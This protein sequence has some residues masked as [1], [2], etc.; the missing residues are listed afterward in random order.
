MATSLTRVKGEVKSNTIFDLIFDACQK[1]SKS[2][3]SSRVE[4]S[5]DNLY[6]RKSLKAKKLH[7]SLSLAACGVDL[8]TSDNQ[9][10]IK[11][12]EGLILREISVNNMVIG[13]GH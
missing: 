6:F 1:C 12:M 9:A 7:G 2:N 8:K 4:G 10:K 13:Q 11:H 5:I 3:F